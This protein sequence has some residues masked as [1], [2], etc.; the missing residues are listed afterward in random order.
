[1]SVTDHK[2][3]IRALLFPVQQL[4]SKRLY[5]DFCVMR[6]EEKTRRLFTDSVGHL[7]LDVQIDMKWSKQ[8]KA[9]V[10]HLLR[11]SKVTFLH[12]LTSTTTLAVRIHISNTF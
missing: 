12:P 1:M 3:K 5:A 10:L 2:A 4:R 8:S 11:L 6:D 7:Q 9:E